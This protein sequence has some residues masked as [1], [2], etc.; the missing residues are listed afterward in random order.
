MNQSQLIVV[1]ELADSSVNITV[2]VWSKKEDYWGIFF[3]MTENVKLA[4]D[5][6]GISIPYPQTDIHLFSKTGN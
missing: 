1:S 3:D 6:E 2:R 4:F 5:K